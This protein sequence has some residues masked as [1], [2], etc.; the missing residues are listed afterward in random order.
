M[1]YVVRA[2]PI[3]RTSLPCDFWL[4][5]TV[6]QRM[7]DIKF[8]FLEQI[9][10]MAGKSWDDPSFDEVQRVF[11][12]WITRLEWVMANGGECFGR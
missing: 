5:G 9:V 7:K 6:K 10:R 4:F 12:E 11:G 2:L 8:D 1:F 3:L